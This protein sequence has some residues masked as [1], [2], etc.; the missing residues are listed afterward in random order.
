MNDRVIELVSFKL[1]E[2]VTSED[3]L[4]SIQP[5]NIFLQTRNG[6]IRRHLSHNEDGSWLEHIE[7]E[8]MKDAK[9]ASEALMAEE[10]CH[11]MMACIEMESVKMSHNQLMIS[12]E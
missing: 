5:T 7:W 2:G 3:F 11:P 8:T 9:D 10:S 1:A 6:F 12:L 4:A